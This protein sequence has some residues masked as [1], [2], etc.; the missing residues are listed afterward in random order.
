MPNSFLTSEGS[1]PDL[2]KYQSTDEKIEVLQ[3]YL[4]QLL[5]ELRYTLHNISAD[6]ID[7]ETFNRRIAE[8][9]ETS[10]KISEIRQTIDNIR[11]T[12]SETT[13]TIEGHTRKFSQI[14]Q[15]I[16]GIIATVEE[17][18][19][20]DGTNYVTKAELGIKADEIYT[21]VSETY[22][23]QDTVS[24]IS[25][26]IT[27][28]AAAIRT[29]VSNNY[30]SNTDMSTIQSNWSSS[31]TQTANNIT[32]TVSETY[33]TKTDAQ[34]AYSALESSISQTSSDILLT[35]SNTYETKS[36]ADAKLN[37]AKVYAVSQISVSEGNI[38]TYVGQNYQ[39]LSSASLMQ[40]SI[41]QNATDITLTAE[42]I[43]NMK[44]GG[45]NLLRGTNEYGVAS[46][47][48]FDKTYGEGKWAIG[49]GG[50]GTRS[51]FTID[52]PPGSGFTKGFSILNNTTGNRDL[53]QHIVPGTVI[54]T[55]G[56]EYTFSGYYR[57]NP[58]STASTVTALVRI[59]AY[60]PS[61][62]SQSARKTW[63]KQVTSA[64]GWV[65]FNETFT[66]DW[67]I[68]RDTR[69][70]FGMSGAG[71]IDWCGLKLEEG[72][73]ATAW[74]D[75]EYD[76]KV[77]AVAQLKVD[78]EGISATVD[79][80]N[81]NYSQLVQTTSGLSTQVTALNKKKVG[82]RNYILHSDNFQNWTKSTNVVLDATTGEISYPEKTANA[83]LEA[84]ARDFVD[85]KLVRDK[86][87]I[88]SCEWFAEEGVAITL[89]YTGFLC[90]PTDTSRRLYFGASKALT[91]T[92]KWEHVAFP[93][94]VINDAAFT[95]GS[96]LTSYDDAK[97][98]VQIYQHST[99][100][101]PF[102]VRH[103][104]FELGNTATD[105]DPA[106]EDYWSRFEQTATSIASKVSAG[107]VVSVINQSAD[108]IQASAIAIDF[109]GM[110]TF[111]DLT[112]TSK[113]II[114]GGV[115]KTGTILADAIATSAITTD[116]LNASAVTAAKIASNAITTDKLAANA[117]TA[118]KIT[119]G[120][121]TGDK[122]AANT[123]AT[124]NL[125]ANA[126][127][128]AKLAASAV[129]TDILAANAVTAAKISAG[130]IT[131]DKLAANA[132]TAA[133]IASQTITASQIA[134]GTIT[135]TQIKA[136]TITA[137]EI[138][139]NT[140]TASQ[141]KAGTITAS[142][143]ASGTITATQIAASTIT[144]AKMNVTSLAAISAN[145][146]TIT[147]GTI[148]AS[149]V[150]VTNI[151]AANI[152]AGTL[153]S[154]VIY[155]GTIAANK[156]T[157]GTLASG[158]VY[159]GTISAD[160]IT[161]GT[162]SAARIGSE[163]ITS[164]KLRINGT[165]K[166]YEDS[167]ATTAYGTIGYATGNDGNS[168][169]DGV[170][171]YVNGTHRLFISTAG[172]ILEG[173]SRITLKSTLTK[174]TG[175]LT[176]QQLTTNGATYISGGFESNV[177][178]GVIQIGK[179]NTTTNVGMYSSGGLSGS[180]NITRQSN[181]YVKVS[182]SNKYKKNL[183]RDLTSEDVEDWYS[184]PIYHGSYKDE[185]M[186]KGDNY[187]HKHMPMFT[188]DDIEEICPEANFH[189]EDGTLDN[190]AWDSFVIIPIMLKMIQDQKKRIDE[191]EGKVS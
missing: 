84:R 6:D 147:A 65:Y 60:A 184:L 81:G 19:E 70:L 35:V 33:E 53:Q 99:C 98:G 110:V 71:S 87:M 128:T 92:G 177:T 57:V 174:C 17:G 165:I 67:D 176:C 136:G 62:S 42:R 38:R 79:T 189:N 175:N 133:K 158:V 171:M 109:T 68:D 16:A 156:I 21:T 86:E 23:T 26:N 25:S 103:P 131:T 90:N 190:C 123:I 145:L 104:K 43:D 151:K 182:S 157:A 162:L 41:D 11:L 185:Y 155:S 18:I 146:G 69:I 72:N 83:W 118:A 138:A 137:N 89:Y 111:N 73:V 119:A 125:A 120:T 36:N 159:A 61:A 191:L 102:K 40:S 116:K 5:E 58:E 113:T 149:K 106:P 50:T 181:G 94:K 144:A 78:V 47:A 154:N 32:T 39:T 8:V 14:D 173:G 9:T 76:V 187:Y 170:R 1:V 140:I 51:T 66:A 10:N 148:D 130:A 161:S 178:S 64:A 164:G 107:D 37:A 22:A 80:L 56:K 27:Q 97:I 169:T 13:D 44:V 188:V 7:A 122:I 100:W 134:S 88:F 93:S 160:K 166:F 150:T 30:V 105:W 82:G 63:S 31:L 142:Q 124:G 179:S 108:K 85:Y 129:T 77:Q 91:G 29:E 24:A 3:N 180:G 127:T 48:N 153:N 20:I 75:S 45:N 12:L 143:I 163:T 59:W 114:N 74:C 139:S 101:N 183:E 186:E 96:G 167:S 49:S 117:V 34:T 135:A 132:V 115:I 95:S 172:A 121:I 52:N 168:D 126:V 55:K 4:Y 15:T 112:N 141:I 28:T 152:A 54:F 2:R 46:A